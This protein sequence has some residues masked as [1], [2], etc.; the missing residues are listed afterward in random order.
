MGIKKGELY[1]EFETVEKAAEKFLQKW[2]VWKYESFVVFHVIV[3]CVQEFWAQKS[4]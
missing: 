4:N 3:L 1:A 2:P